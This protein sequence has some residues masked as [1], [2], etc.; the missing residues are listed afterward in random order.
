M[1]FNPLAVAM[2]CIKI[3]HSKSLSLQK[4][5]REFDVIKL[6][7]KILFLI[8]LIEMILANKIFIFMENS[9]SVERES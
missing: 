1:K 8:H 3:T 4:I 7:I 6:K 9:S 5:M 2:T